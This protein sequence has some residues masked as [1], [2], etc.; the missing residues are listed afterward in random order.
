MV[1][2]SVARRHEN[3]QVLQ[4]LITGRKRGRSAKSVTSSSESSSISTRQMFRILENLKNG[5]HRNTTN[6]T[7]YG[8]WK[9]FNKF[10]IRLDEKLQTWEERVVLYIA[11]LVHN[12]YQSSTVKSYISAIKAVLLKD[13]YKIDIDKALISSITS[14]CRL[15]NDRVLIRLPI[16]S[17]LLENILFQV[18]RKFKTQP[19]LEMLYKVIFLLQ[20]YGLMRIGELVISTTDKHTLRAANIHAADNKEKLL[21]ILYSSKTHGHY[22][23]PQQIKITSLDNKGQINFLPI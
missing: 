6:H 7:Y 14:S 15:Q 19:Y 21:I 5:G 2:A 11:Y 4:N 17:N 18:Q 8:V 1:T 3:K 9:N 13:G 10:L 12:G 23:R 20:Y 22:S 16:R